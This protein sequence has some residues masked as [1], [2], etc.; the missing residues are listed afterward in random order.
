MILTRFFV[1]IY[2]GYK[3]IR[4]KVQLLLYNNRDNWT[5]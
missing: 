1:F 4:K 3:F 2:F 5:F